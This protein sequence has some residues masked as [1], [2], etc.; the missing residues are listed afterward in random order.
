MGSDFAK[1]KFFITVF[2][3][4]VQILQGGSG[5]SILDVTGMGTWRGCANSTNGYMTL[6]IN[7]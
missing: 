5:Y 3:S 6:S 7:P 1:L 4:N 2:K